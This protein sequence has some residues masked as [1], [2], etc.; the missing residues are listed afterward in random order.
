MAFLD[1]VTNKSLE[2]DYIL[3]GI[4]PISPFGKLYKN[5]LKAYLPGEEEDLKEELD[6][7]QGYLKIIENKIIRREFDILLEHIKEIRSTITRATRGS[8]LSEVELFEIKILLHIIRQLAEYSEEVKLPIYENT[9]L[10]I[11]E[12]L[13]KLLDPEDTKVQSFYI[14]DSYSKELKSIRKKKTDLDREIKLETKKLR[15]EIRE[16]F[17]LT[18]RADNTIEVSKNNKILIEEVN[19]YENLEYDSET[20]M[21]IRYKLIFSQKVEDL[22][23]HFET[24]KLK[25]EQEENKIRKHLTNEIAKR[26][27]ELFRNI[28][29]IGQVDLLLAKA[30]YAADIK[31]IKPNIIEAEYIEIKEGIHPKVRDFLEKKKM[32]FT[33]I[34]IKLKR[35][36]TCIT[37][38][39]MGGKSVS[40]KMAGVLTAMAQYGLFIPAEEMNIGLVNYIESS[41][42]DMQS[43]DSG[44]STFG[45]EIEIVSKALKRADE[46]GLILIDE[47]ARGTNPEE[48]FAISKA[49]VEYLKNRKP[50]TLLTTH[51]DNIADSKGVNHLQVTGLSTANLDELEEY[52]TLDEKMAFINSQMDYR[53]MPITKS[54]KEVPRDALNIAEM[55]GLNREIVNLAKSY[56]E[57]EETVNV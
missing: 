12:D 13:E 33:P 56:L 19:K 5:R 9:K 23:K 16:K 46:R 18:L 48:G 10:T 52:E 36:V 53:L 31:A 54:E 20:Y 29:H 47:L 14:Y 21:N 6:K 50:I 57:M 8:T 26:G 32:N 7:I 41:I 38:A 2:F 11:L 39:N 30:K 34:T 27:K 28:S 55:M 1:E 42:G 17:K 40:L 3:N 45:G 44:L 24:Q 22:K 25:E 49:I 35:G 43:T 4:K 51:Y 15:E 37:G